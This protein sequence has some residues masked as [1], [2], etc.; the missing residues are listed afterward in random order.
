[1]FSNICRNDRHRESTSNCADYYSR[2]PNDILCRRKCDFNVL[3][4]QWKP[5]VNRSNHA[6]DY[7][8]N[9]RFLY[10]NG[11]QRLRL[12]CYFCRNNGY[13]Q[14]ASNCFGIE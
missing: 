11:Y 9:S 8:Y 4:C 10:G 14:S 1:M 6:I 5:V 12:F 7:T 13:G 3:F 2:W